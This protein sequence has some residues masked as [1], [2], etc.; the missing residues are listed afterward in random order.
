MKILVGKTYSGI[1]IDL[2]LC[3]NGVVGYSM[4][5]YDTFRGK[6]NLVM[7]YYDTDNKGN[8]CLL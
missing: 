8:G 6:T 4:S 1:I 5:G 7:Y 2:C 3:Y